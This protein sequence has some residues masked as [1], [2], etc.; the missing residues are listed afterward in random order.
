MV[1]AAGLPLTINAV[2]HRQNLDRLDA[3]IELAVDLGAKR[4]EVAHV[5]Y[6]GWALRTGWR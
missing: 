4:L 2:M 5:Q 1:Q 3:I 6:Y